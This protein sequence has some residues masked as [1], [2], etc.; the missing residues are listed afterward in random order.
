MY[1]SYY[2]ELTSNRQRGFEKL[3]WEIFEQSDDRKIREKQLEL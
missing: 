2:R 1:R 3:F